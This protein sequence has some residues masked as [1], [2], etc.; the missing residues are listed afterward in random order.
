MEI[1]RMSKAMQKV[2]AELSQSQ[3]AQVRALAPTQWAFDYDGNAVGIGS[4][5]RYFTVNATVMGSPIGG[6]V[7]TNL[8]RVRLRC[9]T[10][11]QTNARSA[12]ITVADMGY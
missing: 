2:G 11:S 10:R 4:T 5:N 3:F 12:T 9:S 8:V 6:Q 1:N 7:T